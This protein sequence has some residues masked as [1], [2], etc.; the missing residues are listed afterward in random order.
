M[1]FSLVFIF[2]TNLIIYW[3]SLIS[4]RCM[5]CHVTLRYSNFLRYTTLYYSAF[6]SS[7]FVSFAYLLLFSFSFSFSS[8]FLYCS[9]LY[10]YLIILCV[11]PGFGFTVYWWNDGQRR[12]I[13]Y[14]EI[15][16]THER[17]S[18][19]FN[20][21]VCLKCSLIVSF[22]NF[23]PALF[24]FLILHLLSWLLTIVFTFLTTPSLL[25]PILSSLFFFSTII[26]FPCL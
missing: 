26:S 6:S 24:S 7:Y 1:C 23:L 13:W 11:F 15:S 25:S 8:S 16:G 3:I 2:L 9:H 21:L 17:V 10:H 19:L 18:N 4:P 22:S 14:N 20:Y 12:S 5:S